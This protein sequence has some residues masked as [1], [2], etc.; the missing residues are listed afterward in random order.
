MVRAKFKQLKSEV[1]ITDT[2]LRL[3]VMRRAILSSSSLG[4]CENWLFAAM[5]GLDQQGGRAEGQKCPKPGNKTCPRAEVG[6]GMKVKVITHVFGD[7]YC[8]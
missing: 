2:R 3:R 8:V 1:F 4:N 5:T 6:R 7:P